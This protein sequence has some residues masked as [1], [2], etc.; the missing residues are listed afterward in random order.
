MLWDTLTPCFAY[1][2]FSWRCDR[3]CDFFIF[4]E[5]AGTLFRTVRWKLPFCC[6]V[7]DADTVLNIVMV[8]RGLAALPLFCGGRVH[9]VHDGMVWGCAAFRYFVKAGCLLCDTT[10]GAFARCGCRDGANRGVLNPAVSD[11]CSSSRS[12]S[13]S[14][15][16][17]DRVSRNRL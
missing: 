5:T 11:G 17:C 9:P 4:V 2:L 12:S 13:S 14:S 3:S 15:A 10:A 6:F 16:E 1:I 8:W 7:E